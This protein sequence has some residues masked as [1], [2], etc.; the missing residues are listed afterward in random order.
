MVPFT[1]DVPAPLLD[2]LDD[3]LARTNWPAG[4][5]QEF[6][7]R[8]VARW[9]SGFD[10]RRREAELNRHPQYTVDIA[11]GA[12]RRRAGVM[13]AVGLVFVADA[14]SIVSRGLR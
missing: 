5:D 14:A 3:R 1:V 6:A 4:A 7:R 12:A 9:R 11:D 10:W 8:L 13:P 2:D